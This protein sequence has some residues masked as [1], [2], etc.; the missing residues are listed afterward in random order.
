MKNPRDLLRK[1]RGS[2]GSAAKDL[3]ERQH[4]RDLI[5]FR[6]EI[7]R[8][9]DEAVYPHIFGNSDRE[10]GGVLIGIRPTVVSYPTITH[11][12]E[13]MS[14]DEQRATLTFTHDS[15]S[16]VHKRLDELSAE[17][18]DQNLEIVGWYHSHPDFGIFLSNHDMFIHERFFSAGHQVALVVDPIRSTEGLFVWEDGEVVPMYEEAISYEWEGSDPGEAH[19]RAADAPLASQ[20]RTDTSYDPRSRQATVLVA[21]FLLGLLLGMGVIFTADLVV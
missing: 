12:V 10:V 17:R 1:S 18:P 14:A 21:S 8:V 7:K 3:A 5:R 20:Q 11:A 16:A 6:K 9:C 4:Q 2:A 13:A 19:S 15:W